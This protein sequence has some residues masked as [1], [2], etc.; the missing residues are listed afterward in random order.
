MSKVNV[1]EVRAFLYD[2]MSMVRDGKVD[3]NQALSINEMAKTMVE[4]AKVEIE[5]IDR[6]GGM[7]KSDFLVEDKPG[8]TRHRLT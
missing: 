4:S 1:N 8:V 3:R 7:E 2:T 5:F 6:I